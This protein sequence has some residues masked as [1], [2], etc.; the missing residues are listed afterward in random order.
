MSPSR[1]RQQATKVAS[2]YPIPYDYTV[3]LNI[4]IKGN[5]ETSF[6]LSI[7]GINHP[8]HIETEYHESPDVLGAFGQMLEEHFNV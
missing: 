7:I 5:D 2:Y 4:K 3:E 8:D 6:Q 1:I